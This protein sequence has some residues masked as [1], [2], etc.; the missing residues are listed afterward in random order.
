M[1]KSQERAIP[2]KYTFDLNT[3]N[4]IILTLNLVLTHKIITKIMKNISKLE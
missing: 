1:L 3:L 2:T 4:E